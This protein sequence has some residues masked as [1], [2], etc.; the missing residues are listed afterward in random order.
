MTASDVHAKGAWGIP[1]LRSRRFPTKQKTD[2]LEPNACSIAKRRFCKHLYGRAEL[3]LGYLS[4]RLLK[5][6]FL[7][8]C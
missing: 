5:R 1:N 3:A 6:T 4:D 7:P 2:L 8:P